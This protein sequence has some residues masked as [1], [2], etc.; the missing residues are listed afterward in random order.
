MNIDIVYRQ[1]P[2]EY[3]CLAHIEEVRW[4][5]RPTCPYCSSPRVSPL[6]S[7]HRH[8]CN[9]C[10]TTFSATVNTIFHH[11][12]VPLQKWFLAIFLVLTA[13][14]VFSARQLARDL[15]VNK[16]TAWSLTKRIRRAMADKVERALLTGIVEMDETYKG[17]KPPKGEPP[18]RRGEETG[19]P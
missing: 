16:N 4:Q 7:E 3:D 18:V 1:F 8:H 17:G 6:V 5:G 15:E 9:A 14:K 19:G 13:R 11:T 2:T 10:N 12:H